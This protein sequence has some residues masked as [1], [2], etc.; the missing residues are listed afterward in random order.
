MPVCTPC[1][2]E[3]QGCIADT[4]QRILQPSGQ[5]W[6]GWR[7]PC[8]QALHQLRADC[9]RHTRHTESQSVCRL[10]HICGQALQ[11]SQRAGQH[12]HC[13]VNFS[14]PQCLQAIGRSR[15]LER[16]LLERPQGSRV[17]RYWRRSRRN[18]GHT[19]LRARAIYSRAVLRRI[20]HRSIRRTVR[21]S[22]RRTIPRSICGNIVRQARVLGAAPSNNRWSDKAAPCGKICG[23]DSSAPCPDLLPLDKCNAGLCDAHTC[24]LCYHPRH[25]PVAQ[26]RRRHQRHLPHREAELQRL[27]AF[28]SRPHRC[29]L[30][31]C[32]SAGTSTRCSQPRQCRKAIAT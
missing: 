15:H 8:S 23:Q 4:L 21:E 11:I 18:I 19:R 22:I 16:V 17:R 7:R 6:A 13:A 29:R 2:E 1:A 5:C 32:K 10:R 24:G 26:K 20:V 9:L 28:T 25:A 31:S 30:S 12:L 3:H 27:G 14:L